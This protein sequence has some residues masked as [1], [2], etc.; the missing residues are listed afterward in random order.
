M[1]GDYI[2][3]IIEIKVPVL[4]ESVADATVA[5]WYIKEGDPYNVM[6]I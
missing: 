5:K 1:R 2:D 4:P 3:D 6:S